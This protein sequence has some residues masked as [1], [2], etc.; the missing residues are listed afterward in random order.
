MATHDLHLFARVQT[1][2]MLRLDRGQIAD[3][4]GALRHP[5]QEGGGVKAGVRKFGR[6]ERGLLPE[7]RIAGPMPWVIAIMMFLTVLAAA[8]GLGLGGAAARLDAQ[9]GTRVT[10]QIVEANPDARRAQA[11]AAAAA[12]ERM[13]GVLDVRPVPDEE[14]QRLLEPWLGAGGLESDLPVPSLI[15]VDLTPEA[16]RDLAGLQPR[17]SPRWRRRRGSTITASGWRRSPR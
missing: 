14:V 3:P 9:I 4:T 17:R 10:I 12:L 2:E 6:A 5:P 8:A 16:H 7:G 15:D 11:A 1:A 13:P